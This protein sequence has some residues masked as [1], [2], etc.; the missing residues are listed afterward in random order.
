MN[1]MKMEAVSIPLQL[2]AISLPMDFP[3]IIGKIP[4]IEH[5]A[6]SEVADLQTSLLKY[7]YNSPPL[8]IGVSVFQKKNKLN[9]LALFNAAAIHSPV[10]AISLVSN[11]LLK[12]RPGKF[13][14]K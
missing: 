6:I 9:V 13:F 12:N 10:L 4:N 5:I 2:P 7:S 3:F 1:L 8:G 11:A 14:Y